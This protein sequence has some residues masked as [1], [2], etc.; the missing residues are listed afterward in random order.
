MNYGSTLQGKHR[1]HHDHLNR[2]RFSYSDFNYSRTRQRKFA[3]ARST[4]I[5]N[6][7]QRPAVS[8][9]VSIPPLS[10][11]LSAVS[12]RR[13]SRSARNVKRADLT[14]HSCVRIAPIGCAAATDP[15][16]HLYLP[17]P[18]PLSLSR[19]EVFGFHAREKFKFDLILRQDAAAAAAAATAS[20]SSAG[21]GGPHAHVLT[22][23]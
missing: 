1:T 19:R 4:R 5:H 9:P 10:G 18:D 7:Q 8:I 12:V 17:Q 15:S 11:P 22:N 20:H 23:N 14:G 2:T 21:S 3:Q 13:W 6:A 16:P